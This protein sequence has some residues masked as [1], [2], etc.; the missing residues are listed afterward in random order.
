[1]YLKFYGLSKKPFHTTPDPHF[2]FL[3]PSHKEAMGA[4]LYGIDH[5]KGFIAITGEVGVG[6]TT[7]IRSFLEQ[8]DWKAEHT[9]LIYLYNPTLSV[10]E[11]LLAILFELDQEATGSTNVE[12]LTQLQNTLIERYRHGGTVVLLIDEAQNMDPRTLEHLRMLSN[13]ETA[14]D[15]LIQ[16]ILIGQPELETLLQQHELRQLRQRIAVWST[17]RPL[18]EDESLAYIMHRLVLA[19]LTGKPVFHNNALKLIVKQ[20][21]GIPRRLN[22]LC[23]NALVTGLGYRANPITAKIVQEVI[24]DVD[25]QLHKRWWG[26]VPATAS[27]LFLIGGVALFVSLD[28][29][30]ASHADK[31]SRMELPTLSLADRMVDRQEQ[32]SHMDNKPVSV[33]RSE[34]PASSAPKVGQSENLNGI[35]SGT[36]DQASSAYRGEERGNL[37]PHL[38]SDVLTVQESQ[39]QPSTRPD[40]SLAFISAGHLSSGAVHQ[41]RVIRRGETLAELTKE[42]YGDLNPELLQFVLE[43]NPGITHVRN[44]QPGQRIIFPALHDFGKPNIQSVRESVIPPESDRK[45]RNGPMS[46]GIFAQS[47]EDTTTHDVTASSLRQPLTV[48]VVQQGESLSSLVKN[49]YGTT[50]PEYVEHVL[51]YNPHIRNA[52][53]IF[54]GQKVAFPTFSQSQKDEH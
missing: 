37:D 21:N 9:Q 19:G 24:A 20:A 16:I 45:K 6:K 30:D 14:T 8:V 13:L 5:R 28:K 34:Q 18:T 26:W 46:Q 51:K 54:P 27:L 33:G 29:P 10:K 12:L 42:V 50:S 11:L 35:V 4:M 43:H 31:N 15:K 48:R 17:I 52:R 23:D 41:T 32:F 40:P 44:I 22:I 39:G 49:H 2:L 38:A 36:S 47:P 53:K 7:V 1:M 25:R 3:S